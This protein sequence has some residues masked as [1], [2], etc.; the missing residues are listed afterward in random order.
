VQEDTQRTKTKTEKKMISEK[1]GNQ[2]QY[3]E[4]DCERKNNV[5]V[6]RKKRNKR[7]KERKKSD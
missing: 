4:K 2:K 3:R 6:R 7:K 1:E 5:H